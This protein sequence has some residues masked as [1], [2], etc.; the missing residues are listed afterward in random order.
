[1]E[2]PDLQVYTGRRGR[3]EKGSSKRVNITL[4][5]WPRAKFVKGE[6]LLFIQKNQ[7]GGES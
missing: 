1:V 3:S 7:G 6:D 2:G 4:Q 5:V